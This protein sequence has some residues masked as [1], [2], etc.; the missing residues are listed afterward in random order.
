MNMVKRILCL[1]LAAVMLTAC[2]AACSDPVPPAGGSESTEPAG[3]DAPADTT[4]AVTTAAGYIAPD[5]YYDSAEFN[6]LVTA[7]VANG[8]NPF[9]Y[10][11]TELVLDN[12]V[13]M[14]NTAVSEELGVV[15]NI[16]FQSQSSSDGNGPGTKLVQ[17]DASTNDGAYDSLMVTAYDSANLAQMG[18]LADILELEQ[19]NSNASYW[20]QPAK[21]Q[22][23]INNKLF[24][25]TGDISFNDKDYTFTVIFNKDIA[26]DKNVGDLYSLVKENKWTFD[27]FAECSRTVS[28]DLN[29][30]DKMDS[31]DKYGLVLW[32]DTIL[33]MVAAA[34]QRV[35]TLDEDG[36]PELT[37]NNEITAD[38]VERY[39]NLAKESCSINFQ[40][41]T[42]GVSWQN[43]F[44]K[45]QA[46]FLL[47]YFKALPSFRDTKLEYGLLPFPKYN[48]A[49]ESY[50]SGI[51]VW[52]ASFYSIPEFAADHEYSA[53]VSESLAAHSERL[54]TP[55]YY[56]KTLIGRYVQDNESGDMLDIIFD[57]R[58]FD[59]GLYYRTGT[60]NSTLIVML[61]NLNADFSSQYAAKANIAKL[62]LD[63]LKENFG[64]K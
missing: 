63:D 9:N 25:T 38:I 3:T 50:Y 13:Y 54:V 18:L 10:A 21:K 47:E 7:P 17:K 34:G 61:R 11:N 60:L 26:A 28:E 35:I 44:T 41:M 5:K 6:I 20:D 27:K 14:R 29:G 52:H 49:Q 19:I 32:D 64:L 48:E 8:V 43:M 51:S 22:L 24:F 30:D 16:I 53:Y 40:H 23:S 62:Q 59:L 56:E 46:L 12:A 58:V 57:N 45:G 33:P 2:L 42:G 1:M 37:L 36:I 15:F 4:E 31:R 55:A 39:I